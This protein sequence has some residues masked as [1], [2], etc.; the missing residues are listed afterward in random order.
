MKPIEEVYPEFYGTGDY[1][2]LLNSFGWDIV[3]KVDDGDYQ[4]D[5]RVLYRDGDRYGLLVFGWGSCS[6]CD[7]LQ[8]CSTLE[9]VDEFRTTL[10]DQTI[11]KESREEMLAF[12]RDR[13]WESQHSWNDDETKE[14]VQK[15]MEALS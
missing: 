12:V 5:S 1:D 8:A 14:F 11:W 2:P 7:S 3:L 6:G 9:E 4:G 10:R 13:D 15:A